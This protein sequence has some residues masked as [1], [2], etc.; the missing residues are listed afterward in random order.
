MDTTYRYSIRQAGNE[1]EAIL[2]QE[3]VARFVDRGTSRDTVTFLR[4]SAP[5][6]DLECEHCHSDRVPTVDQ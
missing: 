4:I 3:C 1:R 2:H 6:Y 5:I